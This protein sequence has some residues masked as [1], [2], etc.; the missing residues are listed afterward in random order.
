M[1][2][3]SLSK[4]VVFDGGGGDIGKMAL[5]ID[6]SSFNVSY[7]PK[8]ISIKPQRMLERPPTRPSRTSKDYTPPLDIIDF[9]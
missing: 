6:F 1:S 5:I 7:P 4:P 3:S 9:A 2:L 8:T